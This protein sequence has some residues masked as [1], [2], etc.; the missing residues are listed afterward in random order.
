MELIL[1]DI[2]NITIRQVNLA[3]QKIL[4]NFRFRDRSKKGWEKRRFF[5]PLPREAFF[6]PK[7]IKRSIDG[8]IIVC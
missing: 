1:S 6:R 4:R 8:T 7:S 2:I 5:T 3:L